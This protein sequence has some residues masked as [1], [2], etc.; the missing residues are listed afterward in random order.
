MCGYHA[1]NGC[2]RYIVTLHMQYGTD[3]G[4]QMW[5][6]GTIKFENLQ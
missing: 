4:K 6:V 2:D 3:N 5:V 1:K